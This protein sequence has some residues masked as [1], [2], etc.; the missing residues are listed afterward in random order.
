M[1]AFIRI[2]GWFCRYWRLGQH[3]GR[4]R[5][6]QPTSLPSAP[7]RTS[8]HSCGS[9]NMG[10]SR[11]RPR[12]KAGEAAR[13]GSLELQMSKTKF[14]RSSSVDLWVYGLWHP[15]PVLS[16][17]KIWGLA[18]GSQSRCQIRVLPRAFLTSDQPPFPLG[19]TRVFFPDF[20]S[21]SEVCSCGY[22]GKFVYCK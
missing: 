20:L 11:A 12:S 7:L 17:K 2:S 21:G 1:P 10:W 5:Y 3:L 4:R 19:K 13:R 18:H 16:A 8:L 15:G 22:W 14:V 6:T 9:A